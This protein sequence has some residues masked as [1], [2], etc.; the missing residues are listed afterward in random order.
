[1]DKTMIETSSHTNDLALALS[2]T[3]GSAS[4]RRS[5]D[6]KAGSFTIQV[7]LALPGEA[8][9][10]KTPEQCQ[11]TVK[12]DATLEAVKQ[13]AQKALHVDITNDVQLETPSQHCITSVA[14]LR[15][16][17]SLLLKI[18]NYKAEALGPT[19]R[20]LFGTVMDLVPDR[21]ASFAK[22]HQKYGQI[23]R[24]YMFDRKQYWTND[25][26]VA[27][28]IIQESEYWT[29]K[30]PVG[31]TL[32]N[33]KKVAGQG[34]TT[35]DS[36]DPDWK[37]AHDLLKN[38]F[39]PKAMRG[40]MKEMC[41][42][43]FAA[44]KR[45]EAMREGESVDILRW[46]SNITLESIGKIG[47][48][49]DFH[50][51][52]P[53]HED[54]PFIDAIVYAGNS[55][56]K[57]TF[58]TEFYQSMLV[59]SNMRLQRSVKYMHETI[60]KVIETRRR[61]SPTEAEQQR[62]LLQIMLTATTADGQRMSDSL[63]RDN[64]L[65][66]L[67][68]GHETTSAL[69]TWTMYLL[70]KHPQVQ[71]RL[72]QELAD[73]GIDGKHPVTVEQLSSM[74]YMMCVL[75][76]SLRLYPPAQ[77]IVKYC[78][79]DCILPHGYQMRKGDTLFINIVA[80][81][82]NSRVWPNPEVFDPD[83]FASVKN[84]VCAFTPFSMGARMCIGNPFALQEAQI[85]LALILPN[86]EFRRINNKEIKYDPKQ[87]ILRP[88]ECMMTIHRRKNFPAP[89]KPIVMKNETPEETNA[90]TT[91]TATGAAPAAF[92]AANNT[93]EQEEKPVVVAATPSPKLSPT[94]PLVEQRPLPALTVLYGTQTG[95]SQDYA[96]KLAAAAHTLGFTDVILTGMDEW[97]AVREG[98]YTPRI[99]PNC[100]HE[101]L[102]VITAT[103]NG[104]PPENALAFDK[105]LDSLDEDE[106]PL[107]DLNY[108]V[109][110]VGNSQWRSYQ[111]FP[112]HVFTK[113]DDLGAEPLF[114][115]GSADADGKDMDADFEKWHQCFWGYVQTLYGRGQL[116]PTA[117]TQGA[118]TVNEEAVK[119]AI[120][121]AHNDDQLWERACQNCNG[122]QKGRMVVQ[123]ELQNTDKSGRSTLHIEI[124]LPEEVVAPGEG[125]HATPYR[126]GD[127]L[128]VL[129]KNDADLVARI[130]TLFEFA[131]DAVFEI[132][133][134]DATS[135]NSRSLAATIKGP[136][137]VKNA[138]TYYADLTGRPT[139]Y[140]LGVLANRIQK[141]YPEKARELL[142]LTH[143]GDKAKEAYR[144]FTE[145]YR[146][147]L[148]LAEAYS[149]EV[150]ECMRLEDFLA[151]VPALTPRRYSISSSPRTHPKSVHLTVGVVNDVCN[152]K[153]YPGLASGYYLSRM[154]QD[155]L[156]NIAVKRANGPFYLPDDPTV[157]LIMVAAGTGLA[158]FRGFLQERR[159]LGCK[160]VEKGGVSCTY[161]VFGC[162]HP[163]QDFLYHDELESYV[164][165]GTLTSLLTAF[166]RNGG[167][168]KYVQERILQ[169]ARLIW[170][171]VKD[172]GASVYV[173]GNASGM[174]AGVRKA[175]EKVAEQIGALEHEEAKKFIRELTEA[176]RY[177]EDVWG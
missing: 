62:D 15:D 138:L 158:P 70:D 106:E 78:L 171:L 132:V 74:K 174:A 28:A 99:L 17:R 136:C 107:Q 49:Y 97:V 142:E 91:A 38:S 155:S 26:D 60:D 154:P 58:R 151:A 105:F 12:S 144:A 44:V 52:D 69:M 118:N 95:T 3:N 152:D 43:V 35:T 124:E 40:Y 165:D 84:H 172:Q 30:I 47:F 114:D 133:S 92:M 25:P 56:R 134:E 100:D 75:N 108:T 162:R 125:G 139:R 123:R 160:S 157:P 145:K 1:M 63:I 61:M 79:K 71:A 120:L 98:R 166:S 53:D 164:A 161:L 9:L 141:D 146:T 89:S 93:Q 135:S 65:T 72:L 24:I 8:A 121:P 130:A 2:A 128:E 22:F 169:D 7:T 170:E 137:T 159:A 67:V 156:L 129:P 113:L 21:H 150:R 51:L 87:L 14:E 85:M 50:L 175:F 64:V 117:A 127:H 88:Y 110:G 66:M 104:F 54:D 115:L 37:L 23:V 82:H 76:E 119:V 18:L 31:S 90:T 27:R 5:I 86:F 167:P 109:F 81:H 68:A 11:V 20:P 140:F 16:N 32:W 10:T 143:L 173:C 111:K 80:L 131:P 33:A 59:A 45:F 29:K 46:N 73:L 168:M 153:K 96:T 177:N 42:V 48:D 34:L 149:N 103:Y 102:V 83:R 101:L 176:G 116:A 57:R 6:A 147:L 148:D 4:S 39:S 55:A 94:L 41:D 122:A 112:K 19:P 36:D 13:D 77:A 126:A 163:E